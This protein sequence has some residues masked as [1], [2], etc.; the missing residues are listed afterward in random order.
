MDSVSAIKSMFDLSTRVNLDWWKEL[1]EDWSPDL[2]PIVVAFS[3]F[4]Q[5][6]AMH[7]SSFSKDEVREVFSFVEDLLL[8]GDE[9]TGAA[10]ST[11]FIEAL[12][13]E[14]DSGVLSK[15]EVFEVLGDESKKYWEDWDRFCEEHFDI[16]CRE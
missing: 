13:N 12:V 2:P 8:N 4:G 9:E 1:A 6:V 7:F 3:F 16:S 10:I 5:Q 15:E 14:V 11:G